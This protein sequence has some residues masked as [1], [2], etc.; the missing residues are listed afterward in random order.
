MNHSTVD[1]GRDEVAEILDALRAL[2]LSA[3]SPVIRHCLEEARRDIAHLA[4]VGDEHQD[5]AEAACAG[6]SSAD[7][8]RYPLR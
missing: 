7:S 4:G 3:P 1:P 8:L 6:G 5:A 2:A